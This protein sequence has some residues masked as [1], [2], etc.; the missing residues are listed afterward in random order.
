MRTTC[1]QN[2]KVSRRRRGRGRTSASTCHFLGTLVIKHTSKCWFQ[3]KKLLTHLQRLR[4]PSVRG[5]YYHHHAKKTWDKEESTPDEKLEADSELIQSS[6]GYLNAA[7]YY[8]VDDEKHTCESPHFLSLTA[9]H[10]DSSCT[11]GYLHIAFSMLFDVDGPVE[12]LLAILNKLHNALPHTKTIWVYG[13]ISKS[14][15]GV[16]F[17]ENMEHREELLRAVEEKTEDELRGLMVRREAVVDESI[18]EPA[19]VSS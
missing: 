2:L 19:G 5:F 12:E 9:A 11:T 3:F 18:V 8:P 17:A 1:W 4:S 7:S 15:V 6:A 16:A 14:H 13:T 10:S